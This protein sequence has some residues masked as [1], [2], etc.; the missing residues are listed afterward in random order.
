[1][2]SLKIT[3]KQK[4][5]L[6]VILSLM[7][8]IFYWIGDSVTLT[9][10]MSKFGINIQIPYIN[11]ILDNFISMLLVIILL[12]LVVTVLILLVCIILI[13]VEL[14]EK[15]VKSIP[16]PKF[17]KDFTL[18]KTSFSILFG[19]VLFGMVLT[20]YNILLIIGFNI[21]FSNAQILNQ[22][23]NFEYIIIIGIL[24]DFIE[25]FRGSPAD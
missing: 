11:F 25:M 17:L 9:I 16:L 7:V 24:L 15:L 1:M 3:P 14:A 19:F 18:E 20:I 12:K 22:F 6:F 2:W 5:N 21:G 10:Y 8:L 4:L 23:S 13:P